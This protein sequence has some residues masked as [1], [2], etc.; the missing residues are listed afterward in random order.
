MACAGRIA[1][2]AVALVYLSLAVGCG[3]SDPAADD[4]T[5]EGEISSNSTGAS[6]E[7]V[8][9]GGDNTVPYFGHEAG[10]AEREE[11]SKVVEAWDRAR[12]AKNWRR[13]CSYLSQAY[14]DNL[15]TDAEGVSKGEATTCVSALKFFGVVAS[16]AVGRTT[17]GPVDSLRV[18]GDRGYALYH[19]PGGRDWVVP[20]EKEHGMWR[21]AV[22]APINRRE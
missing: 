22:S 15:V 1:G 3:G 16:G 2:R 11:A 4:G 12:V 8:I 10:G 20:V 14:I 19:G 21:V 5:A 6:R 13:D 17:T 9:P 18:S 7:F